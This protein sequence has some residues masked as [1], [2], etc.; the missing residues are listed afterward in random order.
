MYNIQLLAEISWCGGELGGGELAMGRNRQTPSRDS[1]DDFKDPRGEVPVLTGP[2][3]KLL[4]LIL[5]GKMSTRSDKVLEH[6][7]GKSEPI[8]DIDN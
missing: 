2:Y 5:L 8:N 6:T 4:T 3:V 1:D 7:F